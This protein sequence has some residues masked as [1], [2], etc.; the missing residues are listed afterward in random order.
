[1]GPTGQGIIKLV[2]FSWLEWK[3]KVHGPMTARWGMVDLTWIL[4][5][6]LILVQTLLIAILMRGLNERI[7]TIAALVDERIGNALETLEASAELDD[8]LGRIKGIIQIFQNLERDP[9]S[10]T[11]IVQDLQRGQDGKFT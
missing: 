3:K 2:R 6:A 10:K 1:M 7:M 11:E 8:P 5:I 9:G 4:V